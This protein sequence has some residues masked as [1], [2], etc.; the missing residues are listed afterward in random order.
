MSRY[1]LLFGKTLHHLILWLPLAAFGAKP[2]YHQMPDARE[3][4][5]KKASGSDLKL[6]VF[7]PQEG[8]ARA[9]LPL[10][11]SSGRV[12]VGNSAQFEKQC[13]YLASRGMVAVTA[14]YRVSSR[15][16]TKLLLA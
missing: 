4:V 11:S 6:W 16:N 13:E 14:D 8:Q 5:Y 15:Q 2:N 1:R 12:E 10:Y 9:N 3:H 7:Q